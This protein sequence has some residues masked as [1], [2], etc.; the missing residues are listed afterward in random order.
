MLIKPFTLPDYIMSILFIFNKPPYGS[1]SS[2]E[3]LDM[4]LAQAAFD[5]QV[6]LLF[7]DWGVWNLVKDQMP[8][9][10]GIKEFTR[11]FKGLDLYDIEHVFVSEESLAKHNLSEK[12]L[13]IEAILASQDQ[14]KA[15]I[16]KHDKV[17]CL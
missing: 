17:I 10:A 1:D 14:I 15:L 7:L 6:S 12:N 13:M 8:K 3:A 9:L 2:K 4:A 5:Q 16:A 11:L